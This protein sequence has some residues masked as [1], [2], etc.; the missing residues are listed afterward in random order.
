M[1]RVIRLDD[2]S[3]QRRID[4]G[5]CMGGVVCVGTRFEGIVGEQVKQ[6]KEKT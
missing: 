3:F 6:A 5:V 4:Q 2:T 1:N